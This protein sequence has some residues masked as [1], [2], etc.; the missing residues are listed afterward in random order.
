M[1]DLLDALRQRNPQLSDLLLKPLLDFFLTARGMTVG[2][3]ELH[4]ILLTIAIRTVGHPDFQDMSLQDRLGGAPVFPSLG[5]NARSIADSSG[6]PRETVRRK[7]ADLV[8]SGWIVRKGSNLYFTAKCFRET[9]PV[10]TAME[11][12]AVQYYAI[13]SEEVRKLPEGRSSA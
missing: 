3:L 8:R 9:T 11:R 6:I 2:D 5:V 1:T 7:V 4:V 13:L 12:L 10:R